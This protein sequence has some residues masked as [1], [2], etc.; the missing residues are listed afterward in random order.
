[1]ISP[2]PRAISQTNLIARSNMKKSNNKNAK[3][4]VQYGPRLVG[5]IL[6]DNLE[7]SNEPFA[8]AYR[9]RIFKDIYPNT[10]LGVDLKLLTRKPGRMSKGELLQG[11]ISHDGENHFSF[12][13][14]AKKKPKI[15]ER[16]PKIYDGLF[17][18]VNLQKNGKLYPCLNR[19]N[20][21]ENFTFKDFCHEA[22]KEL[23]MVTG[24][25]GEAE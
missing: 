1:M 10:E 4:E 21:D 23:L 17:I 16:N 20:Y 3:P 14:N 6:H 9:E 22:A 13:E 2:L 24:L 5:E 7:N 19:P 8:V 18:N 25:L 15:A 12:L 11:V